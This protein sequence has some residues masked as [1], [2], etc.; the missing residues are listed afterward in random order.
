MNDYVY[1]PTKFLE[2]ILTKYSDVHTVL[3]RLKLEINETAKHE[4]GYKHHKIN[5][6]VIKKLDDFSH[7]M[8]ME[9]LIF[10]KDGCLAINLKISNIESAI[11][12]IE[13]LET[14]EEHEA[15]LEQLRNNRLTTEDD[16]SVMAQK[17]LPTVNK[18]RLR[19]KIRF[20]LNLV[21]TLVFA[22]SII[23]AMAVWLKQWFPPVH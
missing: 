7:V 3:T 10:I 14:P 19:C 1:N 21:I 2:D 23:G 4:T 8:F 18:L 16:V 5:S 9:E 20:T 15:L 12:Q 17:L 11:W 22:S 6:D 13:S